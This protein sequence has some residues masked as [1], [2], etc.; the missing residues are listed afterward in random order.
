MRKKRGTKPRYDEGGGGK[1]R[2]DKGR[3]KITKKRWNRREGRHTRNRTKEEYGKK[4]KQRT[5]RQ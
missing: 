2:K 4:S 5:G 3:Q 1:G